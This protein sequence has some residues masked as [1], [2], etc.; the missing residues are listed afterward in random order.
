MTAHPIVKIMGFHGRDL[1]AYLPT[2]SAGTNYG[3]IIV[4]AVAPFTLRWAKTG[5]AL[6]EDSIVSHSV[7][8]AGH[9]PE[10]SSSGMV[11]TIPNSAGISDGASTMFH[12]LGGSLAHGLGFHRTG[13]DIFLCLRGDLTDGDA[14]LGTVAL[15][16][17]GDRWQWRTWRGG[18]GD[19]LSW[20]AQVRHY[21]TSGA[22]L[23]DSGVKAVRAETIGFASCQYVCF[24]NELT[25]DNLVYKVSDV[26]F[27][28]GGG[29]APLANVVALF[30][31]SLGSNTQWT[32][33]AGADK[34]TATNEAPP[35]DDTSYIE[36]LLSGSTETLNLS[37]S[38]V[39]LTGDEIWLAA[40]AYIRFRHVSGTGAYRP[41]YIING[42]SYGPSA[43]AGST[44]YQYFRHCTALPAG[45]TT[46]MIDA[47]E[48]GILTSGGTSI[49]RRCTQILLEVAYGILEPYE[50]Y[51]SGPA[52]GSV[53][54]GVY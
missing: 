7:G 34:W 49:T 5:G 43:L 53:N 50:S 30:P 19:Q 35:D 39:T 48:A 44:S 12:S 20:M 1:S 8:S 9:D 32:L 31:D 38:G 26:V 29:W 24:G 11:D 4:G 18:G 42:V 36:R 21:N 40:E 14:W 2:V 16:G 37:A 41:I 25:A 22:L 10:G 28:S 17:G 54:V 46:A 15:A 23:E 45:I 33:G 3:S 6:S 27:V 13:A 51:G 52:L 47:A